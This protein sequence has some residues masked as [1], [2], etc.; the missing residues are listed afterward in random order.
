MIEIAVSGMTCSQCEHAV[1]AA[2]DRAAPGARIEVDRPAGR[3]RVH[4]AGEPG[5]LVAAIRAAGYDAV[6]VPAP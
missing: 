4:G 5:P 6:P 1:R 3:V 2:L